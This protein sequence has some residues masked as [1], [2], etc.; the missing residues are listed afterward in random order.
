M[1]IF[2]A[3]LCGVQNNN[4]AN[5]KSRGLCDTEGGPVVTNVFKQ[6]KT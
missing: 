3:I 4:S 1:Q 6:F 5:F 2:K